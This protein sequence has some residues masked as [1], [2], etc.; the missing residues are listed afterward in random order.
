[1][2]RK[3]FSR[4]KSAKNSKY[5]NDADGNMHRDHKHYI[6]SVKKEKSD[7]D[8]EYY[9]SADSALKRTETT[10]REIAA[11]TTQSKDADKKP[12][13][14]VKYYARTM[15]N[16]TPAILDDVLRAE[17]DSS[18]ESTGQ[19]SAAS[20]DNMSPESKKHIPKEAAPKPDID[21][22]LDWLS[23]AFKDNHD[24]PEYYPKAQDTSHHATS[25][26]IISP[27]EIGVKVLSD[28]K[29]L[30]SAS[31]N[32]ELN[33]Y[34]PILS[35]GSRLPSVKKRGIMLDDVS[36]FFAGPHIKD[37]HL[38]VIKTDIKNY[39][40]KQRVIETIYSEGFFAERFSGVVP[41]KA[42]LDIE[43]TIQHD[44]N[45]HITISYNS[46][47]H[48]SSIPKE[49]WMSPIL[50]SKP[51]QPENIRRTDADFIFKP[52]IN[53]K[54]T[55]NKEKTA[56]DK[57]K[58]AESKIEKLEAEITEKNEAIKDQEKS[59]KHIRSDFA[60]Y[61]KRTEAR[62]KQIEE[63][64]GSSLAEKLMPSLEALETAVSLSEKIKV[65]TQ[66]AMSQNKVE[67][68]PLPNWIALGDVYRTDSLDNLEILSK[69]LN[70][71]ISQTK[72]I[73]INVL[74]SEGLEIINPDV[75]EK[76]DAMMHEASSVSESE[77]ESGV[78]LEVLR[79]GY[80]WRKRLLRPA[81][82][83]VSC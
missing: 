82:V 20:M 29:T 76:F 78:V 47:E 37:L 75:G 50:D 74:E 67:S 51:E 32:K 65:E 57:I 80:A 18:R 23:E 53:T 77:E 34:I 38:Y 28:N 62:Q 1:M 9:I 72:R 16:E 25:G 48:T 41:D 10:E 73:A 17:N 8:S 21:K 6:D 54:P 68:V 39:P 45:L 44:M 55:E 11:K 69:Q 61:K 4:T 22:A 71:G 59:L 64:A 52:D 7:T 33:H 46:Q 43:F 81:S 13:R 79:Y 63:Q 24:A 66:A 26:S 40:P 30:S 83:K 2:F 58:I 56:T 36:G 3:I 31:Y 60:N 12:H 15:N 49:K 35:K 5:L 14:D 42:I 19:E 27:F 70:E